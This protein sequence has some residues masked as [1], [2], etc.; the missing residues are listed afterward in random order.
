MIKALQ[1][2][3]SLKWNVTLFCI[4]YFTFLY[5]RIVIVLGSSECGCSNRFLHLFFVWPG[6]MPWT[7]L[8]SQAAYLTSSFGWCMAIERRAFTIWLQVYL[9]NSIF[10]QSNVLS[11]RF[12]IYRSMLLRGQ[13]TVLAAIKIALLK[14]PSAREIKSYGSPWFAYLHS[15][16]S[17]S[18]K[19]KES[20]S[21]SIYILY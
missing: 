2:A 5:L 1:R 11:S 21:S 3:S 6:N 9:S 17:R 19:T 12:W 4:Y 18:L 7:A 20:I 15:N 10:T 13:G 14:W 16:L 8:K